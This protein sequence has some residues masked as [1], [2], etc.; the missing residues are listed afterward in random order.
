MLLTD[1][2]IDA[3][4]TLPRDTPYQITGVSRGQLSIA[5]YYGGIRYNGA[6]YDYDAADDT[7]T[8]TDVLRAVRKMRRGVKIF[9]RARKKRERGGLL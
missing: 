5:R 8:R 6:Q 1:A 3:I 7:L 2:E 4:Q 9:E